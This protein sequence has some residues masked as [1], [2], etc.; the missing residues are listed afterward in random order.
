MTAVYDD[1]GP[2]RV[3]F[4]FG[5]T[6]PR[7]AALTLAV[8]PVFVAVNQQ[9]WAL[10]GEWAALA[11]VVTVLVV[12]PV[13]G[14]SATGWLL[15]SL[16][17]A[18]GK[19]FGW[20]SWRSKAAAGKAE[21]LKDADLPGTLTG[22]EVH[23][24]TPK[25]AAQTRFAVIQ[26]HGLR[27]WAMTAALRHP[28]VG[29][30]E[31]ELRDQYGRGLAELLDVAARASLIS[32]VVFL[33]RTVPDDGAERQQWIA[34]HRRPDGPELARRM[35]DELATALTRAAVRTESF[36]T[37]VVPE[38][39]IAKQAREFGGGLEGRTRVLYALADEVSAMLRGGMGMTDVE[40]VTSPQLALAVRTGFAPGDRAGII[41]ALAAHQADPSVC[42]DVPWAMTGPSGADTTMRHYSHDAWNSISS[43]IKLPDRGACL[44]ALAPVLT[45][46][47]PGERRSYT[48]VFPILPFSRADRQTASDEWAA[49]MG[50]GLRGRLQI[51]QRSRD[52][53]N[54]SRAHRL[55]AKLASGHALTR[56]YAVA[57]VTVAKTMRVAEFGRRLDASIRRAGFA[58]LRLDLAQ[59]SG[60]A[61][62]TLPLGLGLTRKADE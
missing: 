3:G 40:W 58:P 49:D 19:A 37:F 5:L 29:M 59:D 7:L 43:T 12:V 50:E 26:D 25:G 9:R 33:V 17:F 57:C 42:A 35:N 10:A 27:T 32:D 14:R 24:G 56:P 11:A 21:A 45:P 18:I 23:D 8:I 30:A 48:V 44:G 34:T 1:Y 47:E 36:V 22:I 39:R 41:D 6:G 52:R 38:T 31:G 4:F 55:D 54:V 60:F 61:A 51:R 13:R 53:D 46:S 2:D 15:A 62:A 20:T 16:S 28:G